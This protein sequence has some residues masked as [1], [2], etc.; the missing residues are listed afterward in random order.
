VF[1]AKAGN[2]VVTVDIS[3]VAAAATRELARR[4]GV[5]DNLTTLTASV[6]E[7]A[8]ERESFDVVISKRALHHMDIVRS[9]GRVYEWL[10]AGGV[11]LA[12]EPICLLRALQWIHQ[13]LPFH[14]NA[15][16][17]PDEREL[18]EHDLALIRHT[19]S[20]VGVKYFDFIGRESVAYFLC[21]ARMDWLLN[22]LG[23]IDY[24]LINQGLPILRRAGTYAIIEATK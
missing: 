8:L 1:L 21:N 18:T 11:F 6:E 14:P 22:P 16:R 20:H 5:K 7:V 15:P 9:V 23:R 10:V 13:R 19:F 4:D 17:T 24:F 3:A 2:Q 12:E